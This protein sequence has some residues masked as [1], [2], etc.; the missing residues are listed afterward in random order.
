MSHGLTLA[1]S[2]GRILADLLPLLAGMGIEPAEDPETSRSL[3]IPAR[4]GALRLV[5][6]RAADVPTYVEYGAADLGV[7]GKD[8]LLEYPGEGLYEPLDLGIAR[9]RLVIAGP[10]DDAECAAGRLRIATKYVRT[11]RRFSPKR[12]IR[13]R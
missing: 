12:G 4:G 6:V 7:V 13:S 3:I 5:I 1:V 11:T 2:K 8:V 9:C 10:A